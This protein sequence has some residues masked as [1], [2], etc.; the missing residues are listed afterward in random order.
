MEQ[1]AYNLT[2]F[3]ARTLL[4]LFRSLPAVCYASDDV[5]VSNALTGGVMLMNMEYSRAA[6]ARAHMP[7]F[8][9]LLENGEAANVRASCPFCR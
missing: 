5:A 1:D 2:Q 3:I 8:P 6:E 7:T 4:C 9:H